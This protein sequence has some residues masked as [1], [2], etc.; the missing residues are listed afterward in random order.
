[1]C[2]SCC[3]LVHVRC[4][5]V[6]VEEADRQASEPAWECVLCLAKRAER[7]EYKLIALARQLW[8]N[9]RLDELLGRVMALQQ[10]QDDVG[11]TTVEAAEDVGR[12]GRELTD[13]ESTLDLVEDESKNSSGPESEGTR[14]DPPDLL[15]LAYSLH[16]PTDSTDHKSRRRSSDVHRSKHKKMILHN[17]GSSCSR[18]TDSHKTQRVP[19]M[20]MSL[21]VL[22][23]QLIIM[24]CK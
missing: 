10:E 20:S 15:D 12:A 4:L 11:K 19:K 2:I 9:E 1:M 3:D 17:L 16:S 5:P 7:E 22:I 13:L 8:L 21:G 24:E 14:L 6:S 23:S 18:R